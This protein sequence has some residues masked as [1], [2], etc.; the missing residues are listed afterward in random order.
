MEQM[1]ELNPI[2]AGGA[3]RNLVYLVSCVADY[4][5][6]SCMKRNHQSIALSPSPVSR[7]CLVYCLAVVCLAP[8]GPDHMH[9][10]ASRVIVSAGRGPTDNGQY[11]GSVGQSAPRSWP[12]KEDQLGCRL[13]RMCVELNF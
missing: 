6:H 3:H 7:A 10:V 1:R 13:P 12:A 9:G 2:L 11:G 4:I 5:P 8:S